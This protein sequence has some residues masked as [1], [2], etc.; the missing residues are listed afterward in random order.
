[1]IY[2]FFPQ[3]NVYMYLKVYACM[4]DL[5]LRFFSLTNPG[6]DRRWTSISI[7][8]TAHFGRPGTFTAEKHLFDNVTEPPDHPGPCATSILAPSLSDQEAKPLVV[9]RCASTRQNDGG[10]VGLTD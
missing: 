4:L 1:M 5:T 6:S 8:H 10:T 9:D 3:L 7:M 2:L